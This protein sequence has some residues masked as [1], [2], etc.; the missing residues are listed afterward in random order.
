MAA[1]WG[2]PSPASRHLLTPA[3]VG[4]SPRD[5][6][7]RHLHL[8]LEEP[9]GGVRGTKPRRVRQVRLAEDGV[10]LHLAIGAEIPNDGQ[11]ANSKDITDNF[12]LP[13]SSI[14]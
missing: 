4:R 6:R 7:L 8:H 14:L 12:R 9:M 5:R 10:F 1:W 3:P 13:N 11:Y 2:E